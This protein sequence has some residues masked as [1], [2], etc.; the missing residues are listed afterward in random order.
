M[1][2]W[3]AVAVQLLAITLKDTSKIVPSIYET[4]TPV[5][6]SCLCNHTAEIPVPTEVPVTIET[7]SSFF[8]G[9]VVGSVGYR[10]WCG[11]RQKAAKHERSVREEG[12]GDVEV[13]SYRALTVGSR[14]L[15]WYSDDTVWHEAMVTYLVGGH[16]VVILTPNNDMYVESLKC[17]GGDGP[18]R[19]KGLVA[20]RRLPRSLNARAYR[21]RQ[22]FTDEML[23]KVY[24]DGL[25]VAEEYLEK[26]LSPPQVVLNQEGIAVQTD[27]FFGGTFVTHRVTGRGAAPGGGPP[28]SPKNAKKIV[29]A[30]GGVCLACC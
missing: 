11:C 3:Q 19:M 13:V 28:D 27:S 10:L 8:A 15:L 2:F 4:C 9:L 16:E 24:R 29:P 25:K 21:F 22:S 18:A 12:L 5:E 1:R 26:K 17:A 30:P 7:S 23:K 14:I 6:V 20:N